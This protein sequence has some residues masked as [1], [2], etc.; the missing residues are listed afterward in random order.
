VCQRYGV[1]AIVYWPAQRR[2]V[3]RQVRPRRATDAGT[4]AARGF[5]AKQWWDY[6]R[7]EIQRKFDLVDELRSLAEQ[8]GITLPHLALAFTLAH[9]GRVVRHHRAPHERATR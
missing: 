7:A 1:G 2:L 3:D 4:R 8:A 9:P 6:E 5:F